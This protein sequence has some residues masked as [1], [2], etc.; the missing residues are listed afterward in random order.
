[1]PTETCSKLQVILAK[2]LDNFDL[3]HV[4]KLFTKLIASRKHEGRF[5]YA[6]KQRVVTVLKGG[7]DQI[8]CFESL[9]AVCDDLLYLNEEW[10]LLDEVNI[11]GATTI[12]GY[13]AALL[14]VLLLRKHGRNVDSYLH[15]VKA[16]LHSFEV[17]IDRNI[18]SE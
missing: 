6:V 18:P 7:L 2:G 5:I 11:D 3:K 17:D 15:Q 8:N 13:F 9:I 4:Q 12:D 10:Q 1:M 14:I 16:H